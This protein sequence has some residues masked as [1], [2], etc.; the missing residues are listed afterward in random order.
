MSRIADPPTR[1]ARSPLSKGMSVPTPEWNDFIHGR[2]RLPGEQLIP[3]LRSRVRSLATGGARRVADPV[4]RIAEMLQQW[5]ALNRNWFARLLPVAVKGADVEIGETPVAP[6]KIDLNPRTSQGHALQVI[7]ER[8]AE[9][10]VTRGRSLIG[11][12]NLHDGIEGLM[13]ELYLIAADKWRKFNY[14]GD[15][16]QGDELT[17]RWLV[18]I[19]RHLVCRAVRQRHSSRGGTLGDLSLLADAVGSQLTLSR[20][21]ERELMATRLIVLHG[22]FPA[23]CRLDDLA[24]RLWGRST[25]ELFVVADSLEAVLRLGNEEC[26][27]WGLLSLKKSDDAGHVAAILGV[28]KNTLN[29]RFFRLR[30]AAIL[31]LAEIWAAAP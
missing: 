7:W 9:Q 22:L 23:E 29:Q 30:D 5:S 21:E 14:Q 12:N 24:D 8:I 16:L 18:T 20:A 15:Q 6:E 31:R 13:G 17:T 11:A 27:L 26:R 28:E 2:M 3:V 25:L 10:V 1:V 4:E 19:L